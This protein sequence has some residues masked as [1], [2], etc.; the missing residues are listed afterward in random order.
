M[1]S[2]PQF[3]AGNAMPKCV[4]AIWC[5]TISY[6]SSVMNKN[7]IFYS[8]TSFLKSAIYHGPKRRW[9]RRAYPKK[10]EWQMIWAYDILQA[11]FISVFSKLQ[12]PSSINNL[13]LPSH[14]IQVQMVLKMRQYH[15]LAL[16]ISFASWFLP[17]LQRSPNSA[18]QINACYIGDLWYGL[19][20][21]C[22]A[23]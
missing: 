20:Y 16:K 23:F 14:I 7:V 21:T 13:L 3:S 19:D 2:N 5:L 4:T 22:S 10:T 17:P 8:T 9:T 1:S 6:V 11:I 15:P 12:P 18:T